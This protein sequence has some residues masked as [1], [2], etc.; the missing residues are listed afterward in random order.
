MRTKT[1]RTK[2]MRS[3]LCVLTVS[4]LTSVLFTTGTFATDSTGEPSRSA[5]GKNPLNN[6]YFGEQHLHTQDSPDA[7]A[8]GTRNTQDDAYNYCKGLPVKKSTGGGY[9]VQKKTPCDWCATTD[10]SEML[11]LVAEPRV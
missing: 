5:G 2:T 11:G 1:M 7:F 10:H 9:M 4:A 8:M 6:V 3:R